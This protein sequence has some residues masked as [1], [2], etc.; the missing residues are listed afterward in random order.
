MSCSVMN[1]TYLLTEGTF[2]SH[3]HV[4][5]KVLLPHLLKQLC[6]CKCAYTMYL[7]VASVLVYFNIIHGFMEG[8]R[9]QTVTKCIVS[10]DVSIYVFVLDLAI[11]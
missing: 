1:V 11:H 3:Y 2:I 9:F 7:Y 4:S 5:L 6:N 8:G 10:I